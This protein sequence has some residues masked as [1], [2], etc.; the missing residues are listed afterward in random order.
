MWKNMVE[1]DRPQMT[2]RRTRFACWI[3]KAKIHRVIAVSTYGFSMATMVSLERVNVTIHL[4]CPSCYTSPYCTSSVTKLSILPRWN[5]LTTIC[6][7]V[8]KLLHEI[9][10]YTVPSLN[11]Y[12]KPGA[13]YMAI[14]FM[15]I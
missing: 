14:F 10:L 8:M 5:F 4:H 2:I 6:T 9:M 13:S 11:Y 3:N 15:K 7:E 12:L 1:S